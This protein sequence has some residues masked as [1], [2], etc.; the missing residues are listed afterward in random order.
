[1]KVRS[2]SGVLVDVTKVFEKV[3]DLWGS[4]T[5]MAL[6]L[7]G[8]SLYK[9]YKITTKKRKFL[10]FEWE[11]ESSELIPPNDIDI[12]VIYT[13]INVQS[14]ES[15]RKS[16]ECQSQELIQDEYSSW[17]EDIQR[18]LDLHLMCISYES[19]IKNKKDLNLQAVLQG[20]IIW[21]DLPRPMQ[22][23]YSIKARS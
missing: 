23:L 20:K 3:E 2:E 14:S 10:F 13:T 7:Y 9:K 18:D 15:I 12:A 6:I 8:S 17:W 4:K 11:A 22:R 19:L 16:E 21:G 1:M 5:L